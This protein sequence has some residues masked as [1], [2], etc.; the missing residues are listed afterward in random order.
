MLSRVNSADQD[1]PP[2]G[3]HLTLY[4]GRAP[5]RQGAQLAENRSSKWFIAIGSATSL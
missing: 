3:L 4:G 2:R 5:R 1:T